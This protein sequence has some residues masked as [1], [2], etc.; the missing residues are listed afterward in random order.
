MWNRTLKLHIVTKSLNTVFLMSILM[1]TNA[2]SQTTTFSNEQVNQFINTMAGRLSPVW[3]E[4]LKPGINL[5]PGYAGSAKELRLEITDTCNWSPSYNPDDSHPTISIGKPL[6]LVSQY[7]QQAYLIYF[8]D[9]DQKVMPTDIERYIN[10]SLIPILD[11]EKSRCNRAKR[12]ETVP[13][14]SNIPSILHGRLTVQA[15]ETYLSKLLQLPHAQTIADFIAA[16]PIFYILLHEAGHHYEFQNGS[17]REENTEF[18]ADQFANN[19]FD[20]NEISS[21][22]AMGQLQLFYFEATSGSA[23]KIRCRI[24]EIVRADRQIENNFEKSV[25]IKV[26]DRMYGLRSFYIEEY[27]KQC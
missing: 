22:I 13:F 7:L 20:E 5:V 3:E 21:T 4:N 19:V 1:C 12:G 6:L 9:A 14:G 10:N 26:V 24:S 27:G 25:P 18:K 23:K 16:N 8:L 11:N 2:F 17:S 15:Y